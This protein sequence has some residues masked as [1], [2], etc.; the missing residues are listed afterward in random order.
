MEGLHAQGR[1]DVVRQL[2]K[3]WVSCVVYAQCHVRKLCLR[4]RVSRW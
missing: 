4:M 1:D 2:L 3:S